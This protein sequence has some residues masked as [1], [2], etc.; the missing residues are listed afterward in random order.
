MNAVSGIFVALAIV[1]GG[2]YALDKISLA[3]K[4]AATRNVHR[5]M[6]SLSNFTNHLTCSRISRAGTLVAMKCKKRA[7]KK[8]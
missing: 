8:I 2:G 7:K 5:G 6:P 3:T 1:F 4:M